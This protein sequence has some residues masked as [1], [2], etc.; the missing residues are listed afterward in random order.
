MA[1]RSCNNFFKKSGT[2]KLGDILGVGLAV[3]GA[4]TL[5]ID[6]AGALGEKRLA[7]ESALSLS[8]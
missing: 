8:P 7:A 3:A 6:E 1:A 2:H 5:R 4:E